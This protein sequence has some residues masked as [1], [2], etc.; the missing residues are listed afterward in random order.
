[1]GQK[2]RKILFIEP[3]FYRLFKNTYSLD[4]YPLSLGYLTQAVRKNTDWAVMAYNTDFYPGRDPIKV[5]FLG[6]IGFDNYLANLKNLSAPIWKEVKTAILEFKPT[7][8]GISAKSQNF[9]SACIIAKL[10]KELNENTTVIMGGPHLSMV[11]REALK[12]P[13]IDLAVEGEGEITIVELLNAIERGNG[14]DAIKGIVYREDNLIVEN[15]PR[16]FISDLDNLS[17]P[18]SYAKEVLKDYGKYS[19]AAFGY[20]FATRGCPYDCFFC[21]SRYIWSRK[22]RFRSPASVIS[23]IKLLQK[24]GVKLFY[25]VDDTFGVNKRYI[26]DLCNALIKYCSGIRWSCEFHINLA[27]DEV[28]SLMKKAGCFFIQ[29]GIESGNNEILRKMRKNISIEQAFSAARIIKKYGIELQ[30]FFIVGFPQE[31]E[32]TL[33]DTIKAI[34]RIKCD[35]LT[36]SIFTPYPGTEAFEFCKNNGLIQEDHD[37][38]LYNHQSPANYFCMNIAP[39]RFRQLASQI[40]R[41]VDK[42]NCINRIKRIFSLTTLDMMKELGITKSIQKG[43]RIFMGR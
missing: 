1:M 18:Y 29:I 30:V 17:F 15:S 38:S 8:V 5:S 35:V 31:T 11:G 26:T 33:Q 27:E 13:D 25:F 36:Y 32:Q 21:G 24:D 4:R 9:T 42:K 23:E 7:V 37:V 40:E 34:R 12:C 2:E 28:I 39:A 16:E 10:V 41:M 14:F 22:V 19:K 20:I 43:L 3:P 6:G